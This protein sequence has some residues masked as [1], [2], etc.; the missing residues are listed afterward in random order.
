MRSTCRRP[1]CRRSPP[2]PPFPPATARASAPPLFLASAPS[3]D[4][5]VDPFNNPFRTA[6]SA[7]T[8]DEPSATPSLL[9]RTSGNAAQR[10]TLDPLTAD[11]DR[12]IQ[13][14][15]NDVAPRLEG[16]LSLRGRSGPTGLGQL[17]DLEAPIEASFSPNGYGRL[18]VVV[19]P[20]GLIAGTPSGTQTTLFGTNPLA[21]SGTARSGGSQTSGG[22]ALDVGY[23]YGPLSADIGSTP[24]GLRRDQRRG[25]AC[26][27]RPTSA[28]TSSCA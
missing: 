8:L 23:A 2:P 26:N 13:Q 17:F 21:A 25:R 15:S 12:S 7:P 11:I 20:V 22:V 4:G 14:V 18:K 10:A 27:M 24:L 1:T 19:T 5:T 16:S 9:D 28:P 3:P 6:A